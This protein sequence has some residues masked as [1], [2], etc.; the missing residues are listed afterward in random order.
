MPCSALC[1]DP[2]PQYHAGK[3]GQKRRQV[4]REWCEGGLEIVVAT[5]AFGMGIDR[6]DVR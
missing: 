4:Q 1:C 3:D 6:A 5:I 2:R